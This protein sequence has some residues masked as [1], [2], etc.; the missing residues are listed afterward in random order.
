MLP[1]PPPAPMARPVPIIRS[2]IDINSTGELP[3]HQSHQ[4]QSDSPTSRT[5]PGNQSSNNS[6]VIHHSR[7]NSMPSTSS[8]PNIVTSIQDQVIQTSSNSSQN[9]T[10]PFVTLRP[11]HVTSFGH[12][13]VSQVCYFYFY[14]YFYFN[15]N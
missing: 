1:P 14:F 4:Q 9:R 15:I 5:S 12:P 11:E 6:V 2:P 3:E 10:N 8:P 7:D 13:S